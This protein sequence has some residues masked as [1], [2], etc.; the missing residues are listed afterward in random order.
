MGHAAIC[1]SNVLVPWYQLYFHT[2]SSETQTPNNPI[3]IT[4]VTALSSFKCL[5]DH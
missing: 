3:Q 2:Q 1:H 5:Q 4:Q